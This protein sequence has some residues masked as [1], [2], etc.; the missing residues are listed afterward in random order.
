LKVDNG[1]ESSE[2][3][4]IFT[5]TK[6]NNDGIFWVAANNRYESKSVVD[7]LGYVPAA[8]TAFA[9]TLFNYYNFI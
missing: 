3:H 6:N 7:A 8:Q 9:S 4:D 5:P 2:L 1:Y